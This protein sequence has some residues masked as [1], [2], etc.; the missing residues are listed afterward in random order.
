M[1]ERAVFSVLSLLSRQLIMRALSFVGF[2]TLARF[3]GPETF[4]AFAI[5]Q[6]ATL[7]LLEMS[8]FG[9]PAALMRQKELVTESQ[10]RVVFTLQTIIIAF[11]SGLLALLSSTLVNHFN[12][13]VEAQTGLYWMLG[14]LALSSLQTIPKL[15]LQRQL[16]YDVVATIEVLEY[17]VYLMVA[18]GL[19]V[20]G[21][22]LW[23]L[24]VATVA[25]SLVATLCYYKFRA[26]RPA[27]M[28]DGATL[29]P[30]LRFAVPIQS[31]SWVRM[32]NT[33]LIPVVAGSLAGPQLV[34]N[35]N[36]AKTVLASLVGQPLILMGS[37]Q[38]RI[39]GRLQ[40]DADAVARFARTSFLLG[41]CLVFFPL[42]L[43]AS[44]AEPIIRLAAGEKWLDAA[45]VL[46]I[47]CFG[48]AF[49]TIT[50]PSTKCLIALGR[51]WLP[52]FISL[53]G[54]LSALAITVWGYEA[55]G[56]LSYAVALAITM[57][58]SAMITL[59]YLT[60]NIAVE[61]SN[62]VFGPLVAAL[63]AGG[64]L[65]SVDISSLS[66]VSQGIVLLL[67]MALYILSLIATNRRDI[68]D[69][70]KK[71]YFVVKARRK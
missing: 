41:C 59:Y 49:M 66:L 43:L 22:G 54:V 39:F 26:W 46:S 19:C 11:F 40:D 6:F 18:I 36:F 51:P 23:A 13:P 64:L 60:R 8:S 5:L 61:W 55:L 16:R 48:Y 53:G 34:G 25:R 7:F 33:S 63:L 65:L 58:M 57:P 30:L 42:C 2:L 3:L 45:P 70:V 67:A 35:L 56:G 4:G 15:L 50:Q 68:Y 10:L 27:F 32:A 9:L 17:L 37:L 24:V 71:I 38:L 14:A 21:F 20:L 12:L 69:V 44:S 62:V 1:R 47:M 28:F 52:F 31:A 29:K